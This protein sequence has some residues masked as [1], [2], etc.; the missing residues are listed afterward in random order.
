MSDIYA[1]IRVYEIKIGT[2]NAP[3]IFHQQIRAMND[4]QGE[5]LTTITNYN[6]GK[7]GDISCKLC[8]FIM[9]TLHSCYNHTCVFRV[10]VC[11]RMITKARAFLG[12]PIIYSV[13]E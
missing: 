1:K 9:C 7:I 13:Q 12:V 2:L 10:D 5:L 11:G 8:H 4:S 6:S 3:L